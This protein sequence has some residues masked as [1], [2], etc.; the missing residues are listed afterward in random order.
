[1]AFIY[2]RGSS[3]SLRLPE[4]QSRFFLS[5]AQWHI[6]GA[7]DNKSAHIHFAGDRETSLR[8][9]VFAS[10]RR[11][12]RS[13]IIAWAPTVNKMLENVNEARVVKAM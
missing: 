1:M 11:A 3:L 12:T 7:L 8:Y 2:H 5:F 10:G 4:W 9:R 13:A 6:R